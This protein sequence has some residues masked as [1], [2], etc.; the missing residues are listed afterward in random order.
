MSLCAATVVPSIEELNGPSVL[1]RL[2][3]DLDA[4]CRHLDVPMTS[5]RTWLA[6]WLCAHPDVEPWAIVARNEGTLVGA[7]LMGRRLVGSTMEIAPLGHG[8]NDRTRLL[9]ID[10]GVAET[11][12]ERLVA[13]LGELDR[14]WTL[15]IGQLPVSDPVAL[16]IH[17]RLAGSRLSAAGSVPRV[18]FGEDRR[19]DAHLSKNLRRQL[20]K[21]RNR[22]TADGVL[23]ETGFTRDSQHLLSLLDGVEAVHRAR[24]HEVGRVSDI[25]DPAGLRMWRGVIARHIERGEVEI[26]TL[27]LE[28]T[29]AAY[30][31]SFLDGDTY[32]VFDG[33]F[34]TK[35]ERYSP[36]RLLET[37]TLAWAMTGERFSQLDWMNSIAPDKLI[38]ANCLEATV[39]LDASSTA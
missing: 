30:V 7:C 5:R 24:D 39:R 17:A 35:W 38:S 10:E 16:A 36:G 2:G 6:A 22:M 19:L 13:G 27:N 33:R 14:P 18:V 29:L 26:A 1:D 4:L 3:A 8:R 9:A 23:A 12:A 20:Q 25:D 34:L 21:C 31:V 32:R 28:G 15:V 11:M 37:D